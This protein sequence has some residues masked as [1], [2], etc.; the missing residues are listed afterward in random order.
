MSGDYRPTQQHGN[1][2]WCLPDGHH[3]SSVY[4]RRHK[5]L[6][7]YE[8]YITYEEMELILD[9]ECRIASGMSGR[10]TTF[11]EAVNSALEKM[12]VSLAKQRDDRARF[13]LNPSSQPTLAKATAGKGTEIN[14]DLSILDGLELDL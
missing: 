2:V 1:L 10:G 6:P 7:E 9:R 11:L 5:N 4:M 13:F 8:V 12:E 3:L 14:L